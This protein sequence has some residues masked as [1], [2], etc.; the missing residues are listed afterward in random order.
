MRAGHGVPSA[1]CRRQAAALAAGRQEAKEGVVVIW[2]AAAVRQIKE[3]E[4]GNALQ[5]CFFLM[6]SSF[7]N[8]KWTGKKITPSKSPIKFTE[9]G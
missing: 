5:L 1:L 3:I 4:L 6:W 8:Q 9:N 2:I 7:L